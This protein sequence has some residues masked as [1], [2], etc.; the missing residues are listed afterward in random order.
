MVAADHPAR[1]LSCHG[2]AARYG[3]CFWR[4]AGFVLQLPGKD[5]MGYDP[6][7]VILLLSFVF[8]KSTLR[9]GN[10]LAYRKSRMLL[11]DHDHPDQAALRL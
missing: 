1:S 3:V 8:Q 10:G 11:E 4:Q 7:R 5:E 6:N 9:R 2:F